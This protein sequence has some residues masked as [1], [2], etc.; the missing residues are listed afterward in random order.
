MK[1][2]IQ[3]DSSRMKLDPKESM[4]PNTNNKN[5]VVNIQQTSEIDRS[6]QSNN[7]NDYKNVVGKMKNTILVKKITTPINKNAKENDINPQ[8]VNVT[9]KPYNIVLPNKIRSDTGDKTSI[10]NN[11][12]ERITALI[13]QPYT[14]INSKEIRNITNKSVNKK[15]NV[16]IIPGFDDSR[17][18]KMKN[19]IT[20]KNNNSFTNPNTFTFS[21][22]AKQKNTR[23]T[24]DLS[25]DRKDAR[26]NIK[27]QF[28]DE[29]YPD[30]YVMRKE[31]M[32]HEKKNY[33]KTD[34]S[35]DDEDNFSNKNNKNSNSKNIIT[36][37]NKTT[38]KTNLNQVNQV[39]QVNQPNQPNQVNQLTPSILP[40][41]T[42]TVN[43][44]VY[45]KEKNELLNSMKI[46]NLT[47]TANINPIRQPEKHGGSVKEDYISIHNQNNFT[48]KFL[49]FTSEKSD[50]QDKTEKIKITQ[51]IIQTDT[52]KNPKSNKTNIRKINVEETSPK[53]N[54]TQKSDG[55]RI[56]TTDNSNNPTNLNFKF[57]KVE[58]DK[59]RVIM[60]E[61]MFKD[62]DLEKLSNLNLDGSKSTSSQYEGE[63]VT[64]PVN[65]TRQNTNDNNNL[66]KFKKITVINIEKKNLIRD[67]LKTNKFNERPIN[68][69]CTNKDKDAQ[70][71]YSKSNTSNTAITVNSQNQ[72]IKENLECATPHSQSSQKKNTINFHQ[73]T[74]F[75]INNLININVLNNGTNSNGNKNGNNNN[76]NVNNIN[77]NLQESKSTTS[78]CGDNI[79]H[80]SDSRRSEAIS[81]YSGIMSK[82]VGLGFGLKKPDDSSSVKSTNSNIILG[83]KKITTIDK[84]VLNKNTG[85]NN[86]LKSKLNH[87]EAPSFTNSI[88]GSINIP[89]N[90]HTVAN[91][92]NDESSTFSIDK[93][94]D[95]S[96][97]KLLSSYNPNEGRNKEIPFKTSSV[98][99]L[100]K[101]NI[102]KN[103]GNTSN[104]SNSNFNSNKSLSRNH[105]DKNRKLGKSNSISSKNK[106]MIH[107]DQISIEAESLLDEEKIFMSKQS[108]I[109]V[110]I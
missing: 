29:N 92:G 24:H 107:K 34:F 72:N 54:F 17:T 86:V 85:K 48:S 38:I 102:V 47:N 66:D 84:L 61:N 44:R 97:N 109:F 51:Q 100:S 6:P 57:S 60:K 101:L 19:V 103:L 26:K 76:N 69:I 32:D 15:R 82:N 59:E 49:D 78:Q 70:S 71:A 53:S 108:K 7:K 25:L 2:I 12:T 5:S 14:Y 8:P 50:K 87:I 40:I 68:K 1:K 36:N 96:T 31:F 23:S 110:V 99:K 75:N 77:N 95:K 67:K 105:M 80:A 45:E 94:N 81:Y 73:H 18:H 90:L 11:D 13:P 106:S 33:L 42:I 43:P 3:T 4:S 41:K 79:S 30:K 35:D 104:T 74:N 9:K 89:E 64:S 27:K 39:N 55:R 21:D 28:L 37:D 46:N 56:I 65:F 83:K 16:H 93:L 52:F 10:V 98:Q 88:K 63:Q 22:E 91:I 20:N 58:K 62:T